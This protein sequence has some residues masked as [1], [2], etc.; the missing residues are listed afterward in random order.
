[1][2]VIRF[3]RSIAG[4]EAK[5]ITCSIGSDNEV[6]D[7]GSGAKHTKIVIT[8]PCSD[9]SG[10]GSAEDGLEG[11]GPRQSRGI[12]SCA[13]VGFGIGGPFCSIAVG[14]FALD[15][16]GPQDALADVVGGIDLA[17]EVAESE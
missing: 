3:R 14:D 15:D 5:T 8:H 16:A 10:G 6:C 2:L 4:T 9:L 12:D 17:R 13:Q 1:M 7:A 11:T